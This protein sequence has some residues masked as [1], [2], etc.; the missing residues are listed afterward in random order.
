MRQ[1][2]EELI[3]N[4][5]SCSIAV[6]PDMFLKETGLFYSNFKDMLHELSD[7]SKKP[8]QSEPYE[9]SDR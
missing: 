9:Y 8:G 2:K 5:L 4:Y 6:E 7:R 1:N 3:E